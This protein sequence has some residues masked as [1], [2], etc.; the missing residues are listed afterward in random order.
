MKNVMK[1]AWEIAKQGQK[2]FGGKVSEYFAEALKMAWIE[3]KAP[4]A[5]KT[6]KLTTTSGSKKHKSWVAQITGTHPKWKLNREFVDAID[7]NIMEKTFELKNGIYEVC[8]AGNREFIKAENG[9]I[10]Y[11]EY[12]EVTEMIA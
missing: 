11:L 9:E 5:P 6:V 2:N 7:E 12:T 3:A 1:R 8:N 4:K 10:E